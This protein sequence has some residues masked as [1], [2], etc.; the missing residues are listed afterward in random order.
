ML[1]F[2]LICTLAVDIGIL[3][4]AA[5]HWRYGCDTCMAHLST[6][7]PWAKLS[8]EKRAERKR[9]IDATIAELRRG[10]AH[11]AAIEKKISPPEQPIVDEVGRVPP[12]VIEQLNAASQ[13]EIIRRSGPDI[14]PF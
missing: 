14:G 10:A 5:W 12:E 11:R 13:I 1:E 8:P 3:I 6:E 9:H 4:G 2:I 7:R